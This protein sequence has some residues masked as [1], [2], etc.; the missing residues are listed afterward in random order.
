MRAL[1]G[2]FA[3]IRAL[4]SRPLPSPEGRAVIDRIV[5]LIDRVIARRRIAVAL[6]ALL[7]LVSLP[8]AAMLFSN[9]RSQ[10]E[11][12]LPK[13]APSIE[14][15]EKLHSRLG[16]NMQLAILASGAPTDRMH[17]FLD[18][19]ADESRGLKSPPRFVD[20]RTEEVTAFF[21]TRKALFIETQDLEDLEQRIQ[22]RIAYEKRK[23][24]PF[25]LGLDE[26][27]EKPPD[28]G[29]FFQKYQ[30][31]AGDLRTYP[32]GYYDSDDGKSVAIIFY[33]ETK[34][35]S[36]EHS[37]AFRDGIDA[38]AKSI[39]GQMGLKDLQ[40]EYTGDVQQIIQEQRSLQADLLLSTVLVLVFEALLLLGFYRWAPSILVLGFPLAIGSAITFALGWFFIGS[41]NAS[42]AFLGSIIVGNGIN[43]GIILLS[44]FV[45]ERRKGLAAALA[46]STAVRGTLAATI[47]A[48]LAAAI[49]YAALMVTTFRGYS[50]FGFMGGIGMVLC[51][52]GNY[53]LIPP[54]GLWCEARW[55]LRLEA[56]ARTADRFFRWLGRFNLA[57]L[58]LVGAAGLILTAV[59]T[60]FVVKI[61]PDPI[62][63]D[64]TKLRSSWAT[65][66]GGYLEVDR[67]VDT[68]LQKVMTPAV[69]LVKSEEDVKSLEKQYREM[70]KRDPPGQLLG[71]VFTLFSL[72][73]EDQE[74]K[75]EIFDRIRHQL[76]PSRLAKLDEKTRELAKKWLPV[77]GL[78]PFTAKDL[79][80]YIRRQFREKDGTEGKLV[81]LF[82]KH[83]TDT[84]NGKL[85]R[86]FAK[87]V[88]SVPLPA[89]AWAAGSYL[90]FADMIES[91]QSDGPVATVVAFAGVIL[92]SLVLAGGARGSFAVTASLV[93]GVLWT[94]G[95]GAATGMRIN[96]LN[97]IALPITFGIG[98]DYA[99]NVYGRYRLGKPE[100]G[101]LIE[102]IEYSGAAVAVASATTV[103]GYSSLLFSRNGALFSFGTLAVIG[104]IAC[105]ASALVLLPA[106]IAWRQAPQPVSTG[107]GTE[108]GT[109]TPS[110]DG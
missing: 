11:E 68:I 84:A 101:T 52:I 100:R 110:S 61:A 33:P 58:R 19:L 35:T 88:R 36:Y 1:G 40:L 104:E 97:F 12:L 4:G 38:L 16:D 6:G 70:I 46:M 37:V 72:V 87:E 69:L 107:E 81:L 94:C 31:R 39:A 17:A 8:F 9:L 55:P 83:G 21:D 14:A 76:S 62:E 42:S 92:L 32:S 74:K 24:N 29:G 30:G 50:H 28:L 79:P 43:S 23:A 57:H 44:R 93:I 18:R 41:L 86:R 59:S 2:L 34:A 73:P 85:V 95:I 10:I 20:H 65:E 108:A 63:D 67:K 47:V 78:T 25:N 99:A 22:A 60:L 66:P 7:G 54:L 53:A 106:M 64:T 75:I 80:E 105:L 109:P 45:E 102:A 82:P 91:V 96:F 103:I 15:L 89:G 13:T 56:K 26:S 48:S 90:V 5:D 51:W 77:E 27:D 98:V 3:I 49:A 71:Q